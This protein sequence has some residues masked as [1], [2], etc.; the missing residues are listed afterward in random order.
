MNLRPAVLPV[1]FG[2]LQSCGGGTGVEAQEGTGTQTGNGLYGRVL[3]LET[4][5]PKAG[6]VVKVRPSTWTALDTTALPEA[7]RDTVSD[8][9]GRFHLANVPAGEYVVQMLAPNCFNSACRSQTFGTGWTAER[10]LTRRCTVAGNA[11]TDLAD[12]RLQKT[13]TLFLEMALT[14]TTR[15]ARIDILGTGTSV[16]CTASGRACKATLDDIPAGSY[17]I[18]VWSTRFDIPLMGV[19][20]RVEPG[21]TDTVGSKDWDQTTKT[22]KH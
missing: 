5:T 10:A 18:R 20:R 17:Q 22:E 9:A 19:D 13:S 14:D 1:I 15:G 4:G 12:S 3:S 11:A 21:S 16:V 6:V 8:S 7:V 2:L